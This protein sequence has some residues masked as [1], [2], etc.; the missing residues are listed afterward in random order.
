[1]YLQG[2]KAAGRH[3]MGYFIKGRTC[4]GRCGRS[5]GRSPSGFYD[6]GFDEHSMCPRCVAVGRTPDPV[7]VAKYAAVDAIKARMAAQRAPE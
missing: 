1:M 5:Q 4:T 7:L 3:D 6:A 2:K